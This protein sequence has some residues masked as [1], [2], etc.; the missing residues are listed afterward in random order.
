MN[1]DQAVDFVFE[2]EGELSKDEAG[3]LTVWGIAQN[4]HPKLDVRMLTKAECQAIYR[5]EYWNPC[6]CDE[7]PD[8]LRLAMF[9]AAVNTGPRQAIRF[10]QRA[11]GLTVDGILGPITIAAA[12]SANPELLERLLAERI[13]FYANS[14]GVTRFGR[15]W[16]RRSLQVLRVTMKGQTA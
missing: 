9:D 14:E 2:Q 13:L 3:G 12:Q 15:G 4:H 11:L 6:R 8:V 1:C 7:L 5:K 16:I 10:L